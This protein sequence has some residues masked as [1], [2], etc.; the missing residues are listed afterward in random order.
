MGKN[1][2]CPP[3]FC[4]FCFLTW[5]NVYQ[6]RKPCFS[7]CTPI[8][9]GLDVLT[10][11]LLYFVSLDIFP[12]VNRA[13]SF[14]LIPMV[15]LQ[16]GFILTVLPQGSVGQP[17]CYI[18]WFCAT[19]TLLFP[20]WISTYVV[21]APLPFLS[22]NTPSRWLALPSTL[23]FRFD[24]CGLHLAFAMFPS[25]LWKNGMCICGEKRKVWKYLKLII[26][27][28]VIRGQNVK[29]MILHKEE[30]LW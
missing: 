5:S 7:L 27:V 2:V 19:E 28:I 15:S 23:L 29:Y 13:G 16:Q 21:M 14:V 25:G 1:D 24:F 30:K 20:A 11:S 17:D 18:I 4:C 6:N 8:Y 12:L 22:A 9:L 26:T 10:G 3:V